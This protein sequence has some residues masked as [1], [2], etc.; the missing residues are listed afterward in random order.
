M[1]YFY[2]CAGLKNVGITHL[3]GG[4]YFSDLNHGLQAEELHKYNIDPE[5][6][7]SSG[8]VHSINIT[9]LIRSETRKLIPD[10]D[11]LLLSASEAMHKTLSVYTADCLPVIAYEKKMKILAI[12]H[13]GWRGIL[14]GIITKA[15]SNI[16]EAGGRSEEILIGIGPHIRDCCYTIDRE[17]SEKFIRSIS[18]TDGIM[19]EK[20]GH[21][22]LSLERVLTRQCRDQ[23]I[24][25]ANIFSVGFCTFCHADKFYSYR[26]SNG[27]TGRNIT[28]VRFDYE[29]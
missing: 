8:Q 12:L 7:I 21:T 10:N 5:N 11:G 16:L 15:V 14:N 22:H 13:A 20:N 6:I 29:N 25:P 17:R 3:F 1:Q 23:K 19:T 28:L 27:N 9:R 24:P 18:D 26:K 2:Q 4:R